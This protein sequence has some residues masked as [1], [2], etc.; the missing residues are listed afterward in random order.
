MRKTLA[1]LAVLGLI[2]GSA[3]AQGRGA[4][5]IGG[6]GRYNKFGDFGEGVISSK[7]RNAWGA[8]GRIGYFFTDRWELEL[9]GSH[10]PTDLDDY[11]PGQ[12][13]NGVYIN[14][15]HLRLNYNIPLTSRAQ[16]IVG[17]GPGLTNYNKIIEGSD[18]NVSGLVGLRAKLIGPLHFRADGTVDYEPSGKNRDGLDEEARTTLGAQ[19]GGSLIFGGGGCN[20]VD[21]VTVY[22]ARVVLQPG[23]RQTFTATTWNCGRPMP[24]SSM[25][26]TGGGTLTGNEFV[27][28]STA[29]TYYVTA[30]D[31]RSG[32][33]GRSTVEVRV[34]PPAPPPPAPAPT[35]TPTPPPAPPPAPRPM[36]VLQ[37]VNFEFDRSNLTGMA[38]DTLRRVARDL[39]ANPGINI[40][41]VGHTDWI[42]SN[43]YN[44][45]LS[46]A[47]AES[48]KAFL[49]S[50]G[51][52][53]SRIATAWFGEE[54]PIADNTTSAGRA[55]NR[56][57]EINRTN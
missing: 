16:F 25:V 22:P 47:R 36:I 27:A 34:P 24:V 8:G 7:A 48:V 21:S 15:F 9:D 18:L 17:A 2:G 57:V 43:E 13:S 10:N 31:A 56:R 38:Q 28:G 3:A 46:R 11:V 4:V 1:A 41:V 23:Q 37:G 19:V 6:F 52:A 45:R 44:M 54:R 14:P 12:S 32:V 49:V 5:E 40:E 26:A 53:E 50:Q 33:T 20:R 42:A 30:A 55:A 29:R 39:Q 35:P 51:V